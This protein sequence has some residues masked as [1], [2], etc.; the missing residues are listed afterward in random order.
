MAQ[1]SI[2]PF[3][4]TS[5]GQ[6]MSQ[7]IALGHGVQP[8]RSSGQSLGSSTFRNGHFNLDTFS[9]VNQNGSFEF[10]RVL[11]SG[12]AYRR[13]KSKHAFVHSWKPVYLVLRPNLLSVYKDEEE[14]GLR[15]SIT[16]S[17]A[18]AVA[19]IKS[20]RSNREHVFGI[21]CP[22]KNYRFQALSA[23]DAEDW[24]E[25]IRAEA[26]IDEEDEAF[27][28]QTRNRETK[29]PEGQPIDSASDHSDIEQRKPSI[30]EVMRPTSPGQSGRRLPFFQDYSGNDVTS[31][32]DFSDAPASNTQRRST[33]SLP[34]LSTAAP[35][36]RRPSLH[37]DAALASELGGI[38]D[39]ERVVYQGYLQCL[40][41]KRGVRQWRKLW[42]VL[43]PKG[44]SLYKDEQEYS[45]VRIIPMSQV[46]NAAEIDPMSR[47][48]NFC[49]Q[50]ITDDRTYRFCAPD[51]EALAQW[52]G[53]MKSVLIAR[54]KAAAAAAAASAQ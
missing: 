16:L 37:H 12:K 25:R 39:L 19:P 14:A 8:P 20:P 10:D 21:F 51:E 44:I 46:I 33:A 13:V 29:K 48:K 42:V 1:T 35:A 28:A 5:E 36:D 34:K 53:A 45:A 3:S 32:S 43:R 54:K 18:A 30:P 15:V 27:F 38:S 2:R 9:P 50:V 26:R 23:K 24:I 49:L 31:Y 40:K 11:K 47:S 4:S 52:L 7:S 41:S 17:D 6:T 22:S